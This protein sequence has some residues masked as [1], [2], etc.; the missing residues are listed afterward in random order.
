MVAICGIA[1][2]VDLRDDLLDN[3]QHM[4]PVQA[5]E[6]SGKVQFNQHI[7]SSIFSTNL[8]AA[9]TAASQPP[10]TPTSTYIEV[11]NSAS[12]AVE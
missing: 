11:K 12:L 6:R 7:I 9:C 2:S 10:E 4:V 5:V 3:V 1:K 8:R